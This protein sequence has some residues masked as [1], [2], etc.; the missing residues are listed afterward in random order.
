MR[1]WLTAHRSLVATATSGTVVA[2]VVAAV[3]I[4][5]TGY[6]AQR[7]DLGDGSVWVVNGDEKVVGRANTQV[8]E[9]DSV[10]HAPSTQLQLEQSGSTVLL[11][12]QAGAT[13]DTID[14]ATSKLGDSV[15]LPPQQPHVYL[16]GP[17]VVIHAEGTGEVWLLPL[18][19][20]STFDATAPSTLSLGN[21]SVVSVDPNGVMFAYSPSA[22]QVYRI[23]AANS[24]EV[25][26]RWSVDLGSSSD[27]HQLTSVAGQW[28]LYDGAT[29]TFASAAG[30]IDIAKRLGNPA[31]LALQKPSM[32]GSQVLVA[33]STGLAS[34]A[35]GGTDVTTLSTNQSGTPAAPVVVGG[36]SYA[37][38]SSGAAWRRCGS[39]TKDLSLE[40]MPGSAQP[41]FAVNG[42]QVALNDTT[43]GGTWA[44]QDAGQLIDNWDQLIT[45]DDNQQEIQ[46][47]NEDT[48]P[49]VDQQQKPPIAVNDAFG[50]R[51]GRAT[52]LPVLLNDYDP[53]G[54][55]LVVTSVD[56]IDEKIGHV[57]LVT[58]NQQL[59]IT[60]APTAHGQISFGYHISDGRGGT[61]K[62]IVTV[63]VRSPSENSPP[64]QERV[65]RTTVAL[66]GRVSTQVLG[67][68]VD[69]DGDP[70]YLTAASTAAPDHV[71]YKPDGVVVYSDG[72]ARTGQKTVAL[73]VS[74]GKAE[75][76]GTLSVNVRPVGSVPIVVEPWVAIATAGQQITIRPLQHVR[77]GNADIRLNAVPPKPGVTITPSFESGT[78]TF[79]SSEVR[80][81]YIEFT[82][83]D[84]TQIATGVVRIDV[85]AP[86]DANTVPITVPITMFVTTLSSQTVDPTTTDI[87]PAG[88]VLVVTGIVASSPDLSVE[89]IDQRQVR[90]TL[91]AP[92]DG[93]RSVTYRISNGLASAEGTI[94]VIEIPRPVT[95]QPPIAVDDKVTV[96][97]GDAIDIPVLDNDE[98][99]DGEP[100][101]LLPKLAQGLPAGA[102]LLFVSGDRLRYLAPDAPGN[103]SA[104]Y[105]VVGP[106]G[107]TAQARVVI[108]VRE[109]DVATNNPPVPVAVTARVLAGETV[110]ISIPLSGIDPD[111]DAVQ[112]IGVASNPEKGAVLSVGPSSVQYH[113]G[114]YSSGTDTFEYTVVDGLGARATGT[115]RVGISPRLEGARNPVANA[116][117]VRVRPG[118]TVSVQVLANDTDP[119]GSALHVQSV[120]P[121][122][123]GTTAKIIDDTIVAITPPKAAGNYGLVYVIANAFGGTSSA[124]ITVTVDPEAPLS[125]PI[126]QDTVLSVT[127]VLDRTDVDVSVLSN[128]FF[129]D[130]DVN[131]LGVALV[132]GYSSSARVLPDKKI[133]VVIGQ[134]SQIIPF[135]VSHPDDDTIKSYGFIWVPGTDD[136][137]PQINKKASPLRVASES[138][139]RIDLDQYVVALGGSRVRITDPGTVRATHANGDP[140]VVND[141]TLAFTSA[142]RYFGPASITFEVTDGTSANDPKGHTAILTLPITVDPREN[143][144]P[145][146]IGG[147]VD[148]E[149]GQSKELDLVRLTNYP[150]NDVGELVYSILQPLPVGFTAQLNGQRLELTAS[151][152]AVKGSTT[153]V[154]LGV[155]DAI[156]AGQGG[157]IDLQVV[158][159]SRPLAQPQ[160][161]SA[162]V[163]RGQTTVVNV[164]ANDE[165]GNPFPET[166][167]RVV[168]IRGLDGANLPDGVSVT[169][170]GDN[171]ELRISVSSSAAPTDTSLQYE[172]AD[173][174]DDP[175]RMVWGAVTISVQ[176]VPDPVSNF[177]VSEFG[178]RTLKLAWAP[179]A[180]NNSPIT[181][182]RVTMSDATTAATL[183]TT[184]C[185]VTVGCA[186]TTPGNG[187]THAVRLSVVAVNAIGV[188]SATSLVGTIWSDIIP[189]PPTNLSASPIDHGLRITWTKPPTSGAASPIDQYV[190]TVGGTS[191]TIDV[192]D[193]DPVGTQYA[194]IVRSDSI[195]NG[196]ATAYSVSARNR[197]PNSLATWN[198]ASGTATPAGPPLVAAS[199]TASASLTDGTS[200]S[201]A[202]SGAFSS[203]GKAISDYYISISNTGSVPPCTVTGVD[204]G[205][206]VFTPPTGTVQHV[207]GSVS[208]TTFSGLAANNTYTFVV[209][210]YN[211]QG[212]TASAPVQAIPREAP[213]DVTGATIGNAVANGTGV[214]D[215]KLSAVSI[216]AGSS[217]VDSFEY[218]L[219]GGTVDSSQYGPLDFNS[220]LTSSG[221]QYGNHVSV[222]VRGCRAYPEVVL[223]SPD[224]SPAFDVGTPVRIGLGGLATVVTKDP[225]LSGP[226]QGYWTWTSAPG[227]S[228]YDNVQI[229]CGPDD[230]PGTPQCEVVGGGVLG[231]QYPD[232]QVD[233]S[234]NGTTYTRVYSWTDF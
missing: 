97:V 48:P 221:T 13:L 25:D 107:Q 14:T 9:L 211:G 62:A 143:Q 166:P 89:V 83:T 69:P 193:S 178:D 132:Q 199:P 234:A 151:P 47:P 5:S 59:Q 114:D 169:P 124:F 77:G 71:G 138:L 43:G 100:I 49:Q 75:G 219:V 145:V 147:V 103:Y 152:T 141:H 173:A 144:P 163:P 73:V 111:G 195:P 162:I 198:A 120:T 115:I 64:H 109:K 39:D 102:G 167:L 203:N 70:F 46:Q 29:G 223:C 81:H 4:V 82:V 68:W 218:R 135:S 188:S 170:S 86:P 127:D 117:T 61:A 185:T 149:P 24:D 196:A 22:G 142:D 154:S 45:P 222:Q 88:G 131:D 129:A 153:S 28:A 225:D 34:V 53:N 128:V 90:V 66:G 200:A 172:V 10:V 191:R 26:A 8:L 2:A 204:N 226:G 12:D 125:F 208:S 37:A 136:A 140:L 7:M 99:P 32:T 175:T 57:D 156:N 20:L 21:G 233:V 80:T 217:D 84:G 181:E 95:L 54:D 74:D 180:F 113:A 126:V 67:D 110:S 202:W 146:F 3:A 51:P 150:Y 91:T 201:V 33:S 119:D 11:V 6:T 168:D 215:F 192:D 214:W 190:L 160:P 118:R 134:H 158:P 165:A 55:V 121:N 106:D 164:L 197:A 87:D 148:F 93:P 216:A 94:S 227:G 50:A 79:T 72:G 85:S 38:W 229:S 42:D 176:D 133:R 31:T 92:L 161:D 101:T 40:Q 19:D 56:G 224:W 182:Y 205:N 76:T 157:R 207:D 137:L 60:L 104:V 116:D 210:A 78:F 206:P 139:L 16:A 35:L 23:D 177:R 58:R 228:G 112:L 155:K 184:S 123:P 17:R 213:G 230:D 179:G 186:I 232:L 231:N 63:T 65:T 183:S 209:F 171:S 174:T 187:P 189:P 220:F 212:C 159:S 30:T 18:G 96:R 44:V 108:S 41:Q 15:A 98:Q 1:A 122:L 52:V 27:E 194:R 105:S 130:G 36:C